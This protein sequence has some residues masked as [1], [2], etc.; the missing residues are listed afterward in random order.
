MRISARYVLFVIAIALQAG[1]VAANADSAYNKGVDAFRVKDFATARQHWE[2]AIQSNDPLAQNNL[3]YLLYY[4]MGGSADQARAVALWRK[5]AVAAHSEAQ[6]HLGQAYEDGKAL[7]QNY[8]EAYSWY[9]C[10]AASAKATAGDDKEYEQDLANDAR[11]SLEKLL[12]KLSKE[13]FANGE[14]LAKQCIAKY[15]GS[16]Q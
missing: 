9:R 1:T 8:A 14:I 12:S 3:G 6:W 5:A 4:G 11:Q 10:A 15:A 13:D 7:S 16:D 2:V